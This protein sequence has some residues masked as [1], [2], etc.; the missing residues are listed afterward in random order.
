MADL[1]PSSI[2]LATLAWLAGSAANE[3]LLGVVREAHPEIRNAHGYVFQHLL[4]GPCTIGELA[5]RLGVTQQAASK[6]VGE[7]T[8]L[9]YVTREPD[10]ADSRVRRVALSRRGRAVVA[11]GRAARAAL[12]DRLVGAVGLAAV[13]QAREALVALLTEIGGV[14]AVATRRVKAPSS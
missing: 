7:L 5:A 6:V 4:V 2:D 8:T 12:E 11:R 3:H 10:E 13:N 9:G 1:D 14:K